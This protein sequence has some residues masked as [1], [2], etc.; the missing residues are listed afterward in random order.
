ME[1]GAKG[2]F[3]IAQL[4]KPPIDIK[5][6]RPELESEYCIAGEARPRRS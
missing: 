1:Q 5:P 4:E 6:Y 3:S 2:K